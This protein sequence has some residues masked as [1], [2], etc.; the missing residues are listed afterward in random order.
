MKKLIL[1]ASFITVSVMVYFQLSNDTRKPIENEGIPGLRIKGAWDYEFMRLVDP[2]TGKIPANIMLKEQ[3]F[4]KRMF[5]KSGPETLTR[6]WK[7]AGPTNFGGR[8]RAVAMDITNSSRILAAG[9]SGGLFDSRD[10]GQSWTRVTPI[11]ESFAITSLA[12]DTRIG[13]QHIWYAGTGELRGNSATGS[14]PSSFYLGTGIY[15][16]TDSAKTWALLPSTEVENVRDS[17]NVFSGSWDIFVPTFDTADI[18]YAATGGT[19][20]KSINGGTTWNRVLGSLGVLEISSIAELKGGKNNVMYAGLTSSNNDKGIWRSV[21]GNNWTNILP[22]NFPNSYGRIAIGIDPHNEN[23]VYFLAVTP[24]AG[25][26]ITDFGGNTYGISLYRYTYLA[27]DGAGTNGFWENLSSRLPNR[28]TKLSTFNT[29]SGYDMFMRV[30]PF[31]SMIVYV[32]GT[33]LERTTDMFATDTLVHVGGYSNTDASL[34]SVID[35]GTFRFDVIHHPD[36]H[37]MLFSKTDTGEAYVFGDGGAHKAIDLHA[38]G[39]EAVQYESLSNGYVTAQFYTIA[40]N[41]YLKSDLRLMGGTQDND[42]K[43]SNLSDGESDFY[44]TILFG[45][46]AHCAFSSDPNVVYASKQNAKAVKIELDEEGQPLRFV[47]IQPDGIEGFLFINP[48]LLDP[49]DDNVMYMAGGR[50]LWRNDDLKNIAYTNAIEPITQGWTRFTKTVIGAITSF[51]MAE[52]GSG[53]LYIG[54]SKGRMYKLDSAATTNEDIEL[55]ITSPFKQGTPPDAYISSISVD[56]DDSKTVFFS[57][58]NYGV[59]S[60]FLTRDGGDTYTSLGG[61]LE[62][63]PN[64]TGNGPSVRSVKILP[65]SNGERL[66]LVG[67]ST[68]LYCSSEITDSTTQ[69]TKVAPSVIGNSIIDYIDARNEDGYIALASHGNGNFT[70]WLTSKYTLDVKENKL[71]DWQINP[72]PV[73]DVANLKFPYNY[74]GEL[75]IYSVGGKLVK[76]VKV[77]NNVDLSFLPKGIYLVK[78]DDT[79]LGVKR[80]VKS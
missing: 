77:S 16:S 43:L 41:H 10:K 23:R 58:S 54:T 29:Q 44:H 64:G 49:N 9:V 70:G 55:L 7:S 61:N 46:G 33:N 51:A 19:I 65:L 1:I 12:Q 78:P 5:Y 21:D 74:N 80:I 14:Y 53:T 37:N 11:E 67:T 2:N 39:T 69:W 35:G 8:T 25:K 48:L 71:L 20:E 36:L 68:G 57:Y 40:V 72:N 28:G 66:Y 63:F 38:E 56:P 24:G 4:A 22:N 42:T 13:K 73:K 59:K 52:D 79:R 15:K 62:E 27:G 60:L 30:D 6:D 32:G 76:K 50:N 3:Q 75:S 34:D 31:D 47:G 26:I 45:D 17:D 18:V